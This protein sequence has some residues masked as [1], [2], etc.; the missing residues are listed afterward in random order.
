MQK[1]EVNE[2]FTVDYQ[3]TEEDRKKIPDEFLEYYKYL[4]ELKAVKEFKQKI[5]SAINKQIVPVMQ[6]QL[7]KYGE[8]YTATQ[9]GTLLNKPCTV[10]GK[11]VNKL[12]LRDSS[13]KVASDITEDEVLYKYF[14]SYDIFIKIAKEL[15]LLKKEPPKKMVCDMVNLQEQ[16]N[17]GYEPN[18]NEEQFIEFFYDTYIKIK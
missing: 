5:N 3:I 7:N 18:E 15:K 16:I 2:S 6:P 1:I 17:F 14:Y 8:G 12:G 10:I 11:T 13:Q 4:K 9:I